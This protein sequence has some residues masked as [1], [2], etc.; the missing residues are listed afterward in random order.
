MSYDILDKVNSPK[1]LKALDKKE[2]EPLC[3][4][5][6][7]FLVEKVGK[8]GGHLASNLGVCEL[9]VA[10]HRIFD[11]PRDHIIFDVGHQSYVHKIL[12]GRKRDFDSLRKSGGL[13]GF[14]SMK[15]SVHD[16]FGAGHSSTSVSSALG[17]AETDRMNGTDAYSVAVV[18]DGAYTGGMIHEALNNCK[19]GLKLIIVLNEN[20]MSISLNKGSFATY[21]SRVRASK[22][23]LSW[24]SGTKSALNK[25]PLIGKAISRC[26]AFFKNLF[27]KLFFSP[28][29][30][31]DLGLYYIGPVD[32]NNYKQ[33]EGAL[34]KAKALGECVV[35]HINT[36]KGKGYKPA[37]MSPDG[38]HSL[39]MG[40]NQE[41]SY[42]SV[43]AEKLI[44]LIFS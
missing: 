34:R 12:T 2:I 1:D 27:K 22:R 30:F 17:Y 29:Y 15:E 37:E 28:N 10:L 14:T 3:E 5:I 11:S 23:Y 24:K 32:G 43:F 31:E 21:I 42:H 8:Q 25:I 26:F 6:R 39:H 4:E 19:P 41:S 16:A 18:G 7:E 9:T 38:F 13:S 33:V 20:G 44:S 40:A 35:V 36:T